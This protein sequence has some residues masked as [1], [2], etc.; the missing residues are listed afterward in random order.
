M[1]E[2]S[3]PLSMVKVINYTLGALI[4]YPVTT[5]IQASSVAR[6]V[7]GEEGKHPEISP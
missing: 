5:K 6:E 2:N 1:G 4:H 7:S 3:I